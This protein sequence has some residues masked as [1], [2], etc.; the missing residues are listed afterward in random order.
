MTRAFD[1]LGPVIVGVHVD[2]R[3][4]HQLFEMI[5][6]DRIHYQAVEIPIPRSCRFTP[7]N[8]RRLRRKG[9]DA[10]EGNDRDRSLPTAGRD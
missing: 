6:S 2:H 8:Q 7:E 10:R 4:N 5:K 1:T 3:D 9:S